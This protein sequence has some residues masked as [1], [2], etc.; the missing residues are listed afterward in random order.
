LP[1]VIAI[2]HLAAHHLTFVMRVA[3]VLAGTIVMI[4]LRA[5][6]VR[7]QPFEPSLVILMKAGLVVVDEDRR[8]DVHRIDEAKPLAHAALLHRLL[9]FASDVHEIHPL[10]HFHSE[11]F[12]MRQHEGIPPVICFLI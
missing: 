8:G 11:V 12:R 5:R 10:R 2:Y 7:R 3:V 1:A 6:V 4:A 9:N